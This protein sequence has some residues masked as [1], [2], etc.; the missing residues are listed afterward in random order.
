MGREG[1]GANTWHSSEAVALLAE[2]GALEQVVTFLESQFYLA[3]KWAK[4]K[5]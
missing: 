4:G 5:V 2:C 1:Y 3:V